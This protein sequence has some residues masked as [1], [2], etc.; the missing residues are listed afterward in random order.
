[1]VSGQRY[2]ALV[3]VCSIACRGSEL[4]PRSERGEARAPGEKPVL[5]TDPP[6]VARMLNVPVDSLRAAAEE[7]YRRESYD[8]AAAIFRAELVRATNVRDRN[9]EARAHMWLGMAAWRLGDYKQARIDGEQS[10]SMKRALGMDNELSRSFNALGLLAWNE[11]RERD[12][13]QLFD[14]ALAAARRNHDSTGFARASA[15]VP[16]VRLELGDFEGARKALDVALPA[17]RAIGDER[18]EAND[19]ANLA[20]L[21]IRVGD[22]AAALPLLADARRH[23]RAIS[24]QTGEANALGQLATAWGQLGDLQRAIAA[25]DSALSVA[26]GE[27]LTQEVAADLE[28]IADLQAQAGDNQLALRRLA[29]ADSLDGQLGLATERG[30]N[31]RRMSTILMAVGDTAGSIAHARQA[32]AMHEKTEA[33][34]QVVYDRL[35]LAQTLSANRSFAVA[36]AELD[37]ALLEARK[38]DD[39]ALSR[40]AAIANARLALDA[41]DPRRVLEILG[42]V[43]NA[44]ASDWATSDLRAQA[45]LSLGRL[46]DARREARQS[47]AALERERASLGFGPLRSGY[48]GDRAAPYSHLVAIELARHDTTAAFQ[49]VAS[50]PGRSLTERLG[51]IAH[52]SPSIVE[53]AEGERLLLRVASLEDELSDLGTD[54]KFAERRASLRRAIQNGEAEYTDHLSRT[55]PA[56]GIVTVRPPRLSEIQSRL[57]G[58]EALIVFLSGPDHLDAFAVSR[59]RIAYRQALLGSEELRTRIRVVRELLNRPTS[60]PARNAL[61]DLHRILLDPWKD[62]G[63]L[64]GVDHLVIVPHAA[65]AAL[66]FAALWNR[67]SGRFAVEDYAITTLPSVAALAK[68][69]DSARVDLSRPLVLAPLANELPGTRREANAIAHVMPGA[70]VKLGTAS[71]EQAALGGLAA[72]RPLHIASHGSHNAQNPLFS[73]MVVSAARRE[74]S[75]SDGLLEVHEILGLSTSSPLVYLSGCETALGQAADNAFASSSDE[76]SLAESFLIAGARTVVATLWR[77]DDAGAASIAEGFYTRLRSGGSPEDALAYAQRQ[78]LKGAHNFT[79]ASYTIASTRPRSTAASH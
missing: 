50:V 17:A 7:R 46:D 52:P 38:L 49:V 41:R 13:L 8:S 42:K 73:R 70:E 37:T 39:H 71:T 77:V 44:A 19:L 45:L 51:A 3:L 74:S 76:N 31:M 21:E 22:A 20:M 48:L 56:P 14:S 61:A 24:Y 2:L 75:A 11:G 15:N 40:D 79:W 26:R 33:K 35:R 28:V 57:S 62:T 10:V 32:L 6:T 23:Y 58:G 63:V 29:L 53:V 69:C 12:A 47:I 4:S 55:A 25:A 18:L 1:M 54:A 9:A 34:E 30:T 43:D 59:D 36:R 27:G 60:V 65:L 66:P 68:C 78:A 64:R 16:L 67:A 5:P 72:G